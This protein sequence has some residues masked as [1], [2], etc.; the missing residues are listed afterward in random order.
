MRFGIGAHVATTFHACLSLDPMLKASLLR[1]P[2]IQHRSIFLNDNAR[3]LLII[4]DVFNL[5]TP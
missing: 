5:V 3:M 4:V 1:P 2:F